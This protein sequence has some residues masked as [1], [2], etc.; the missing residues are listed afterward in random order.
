MKKNPLFH[1][2]SNAVK[3]AFTHCRDIN[4]PSAIEHLNTAKE[5]AQNF[6]ANR[7]EYDVD[8]WI[9][10]INIKNYPPAIAEM[11]RC[12]AVMD[13]FKALLDQEDG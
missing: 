11:K 7:L 12:I 8:F 5:I 9:E 6:D 4:F 10:S 1:D 13:N 2:F 3:A